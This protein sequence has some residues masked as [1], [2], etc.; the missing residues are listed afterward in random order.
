MR[1]RQT[2]KPKDIIYVGIDNGVTGSIGAVN[3]DG[4]FSL[5]CLTPVFKEQNYTKKKANINRLKVDVFRTI[6]VKLS[7]A[8]QLRIFIERPMVNPTMFKAT[9]SAVRCLEATL[10]TL[11]LAGSFPYQYV[12]SKEWQKIML[13]KGTKGTP[14]LK[15]A[16]VDIG[17]RLFPDHE[18]LIRK[19]KDADS[20]LMAEAMRRMER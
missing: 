19:H 15:K 11:A 6:I 9:L 18:D 13:P 20:I 8:G 16:S 1:T 14:A 4:S 17:L 12:D 3:K 10:V 2:T 5:F 7:E